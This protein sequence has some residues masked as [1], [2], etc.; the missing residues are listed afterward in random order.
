MSCKPKSIGSLVL[1]RRL[2]PAAIVDPLVVT[3]RVRSLSE[4]LYVSLCDHRC[5]CGEFFQSIFQHR[6]TENDHRGTESCLFQK[7]PEEI[8]SATAYRD[9]E[10]TD[11]H[12]A[13]FLALL[14]V[15]RIEGARSACNDA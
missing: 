12:S 9:Y 6:G 2:L 10:K 13:R 8:V 14:L 7:I 11:L 1:R 4:A 15:S 3:P 5:R